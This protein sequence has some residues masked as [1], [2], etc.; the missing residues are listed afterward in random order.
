MQ[1]LGRPYRKIINTLSLHAVQACLHAMPRV[2]P[3]FCIVF[4]L[5][6]LNRAATWG[7]SC[8]QG[9]CRLE[10]VAGSTQVEPLGI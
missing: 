4:L 2:R 9:V 3:V 10:V 1:H 5:L 6:T 8:G 7:T